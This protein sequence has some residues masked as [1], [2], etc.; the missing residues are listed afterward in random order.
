MTREMAV[1]QWSRQLLQRDKQ[2]TVEEV[3][4]EAGGIYS[5]AP[6]SY[7]SFVARIPEFEKDDLDR[8]L[9]RDRTLVRLSA[10]RGS[11][12]LIPLELIDS[13]IAAF[14]RG[15]VFIIW[16]KKIVGLPLL[17]K[18]SDQILALLT[19][20]ILPARS[21]R[22]E[23]GVSAG[24]SEAFRFLLSSMCL[25]RDLAAASGA[26]GWRDNQY[27]YALWDEWFTE[28]EPVAIDPD[29]ARVEVAHWYLSG[30]GPGTI[31][32]FAWWAGLS[33]KNAAAALAN[34]DEIADGLYDLETRRPLA[35]PSGLR[36]LPIWDTALVAPR[37]KRRMVRT[38]HQPYVYDRSGNLTSTIVHEAGVIGVW[39]RGGD[40]QHL[41]IRAAGFEP[42][43]R[44]VR[45]L[46]EA[47]AAVLASAVGVADFR[48]SFVDEPVDLLAAPLNRFMSPLKDS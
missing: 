20:Q 26:K 12:F 46:V 6:T 44:T 22:A 25:N 9:Y 40:S 29:Q 42:F 27:G 14:D 21:I 33:K 41:D 15:D 23:L 43:S 16:A 7:L 28:H 3:V 32:H 2:F 31:D 11:G 5:T 39:S 24:E 37:G 17:A 19:G 36:L 10:L 38:V 35:D 8:A 47:E 30:H 1:E 4:S 18:W 48:V 34:F 45:A 13:V